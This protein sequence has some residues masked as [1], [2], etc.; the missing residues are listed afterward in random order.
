MVK[1]RLSSKGQIVIPKKVREAL[2]IQPGDE[3]RFD[4]QDGQAVIRPARSLPLEQLCGR[5]AGKRPYPGRQAERTAMEQEAAHE[6]LN[7]P[8]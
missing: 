7:G 6:A 3:V 8:R 5:L 2:H 1:A 4:L